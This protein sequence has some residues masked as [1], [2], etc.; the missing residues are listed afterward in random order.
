MYGIRVT[1]AAGL[2][3]V[4]GATQALDVN[5]TP[6]KPYVEVIHGEQLIRVHRVQDRSHHLTGGWTKTSRKCPPFCIQPMEAA[7]GVRT[8]GQL[9]L[10]DFMESEL[11]NG[12]GAL[13]D[14]RTESWYK[15]G[16]IPGSVHVPFHVF[17]MEPDADELLTALGSFGVKPRGQVGMLERQL[18]RLGLGSDLKNADWDFSEAK[19]LTVWCNGPWCGQSPAAI[20]NLIKLGYPAEKLHYYRGGMQAWVMLGLTTIVPEGGG[21]AVA[22]TE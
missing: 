7:P 4:A 12:T 15:R 16:T 8:V 9:E 22:V 20:R 13:V 5:I 6:E 14:A 17:A 11:R 1:L 3:A 21:H 10:L 2:L 19:T 18:E